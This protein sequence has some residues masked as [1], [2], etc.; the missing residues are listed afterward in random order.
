MR[1]TSR[2]LSVAGAEAFAAGLFVMLV[3]ALPANAAV[4]DVELDGNG[5]D[6]VDPADDWDVITSTGG[7]SVIATPVIPDP[8]GNNIFTTGGSKDIE[9]V[10]SWAW[11]EGSVPD[12]DEIT[13]AMAALYTGNKLYFA[14]DR[15]ANNGD[16]SLGFWL[17]QNPIGLEPDGSFSG[18][19]AVGD[20]L[21]LA[22]FVQGGATTIVPRV[23]R[24]VGDGSGSEGNID[25][26]IVGVE[27]ASA[28][29]NALVECAPWPYEP[30]FPEECPPGCDDPNCHPPSSFFEGGLDLGLLGV[31][32]CFSSFLVETR[33]SQSVSAQLKDFVLGD[34]TTNPTCEITGAPELCEGETAEYCS[35]CDLSIGTYLWEVVSGDATIVG[36]DDGSC[37][38]VQ[39]G[40]TNFTLKLSVVG[41]DGCPGEFFKEVVV[42]PLPVCDIGGPDEV[43]ED[44]EN[45]HCASCGTGDFDYAWSIAGDG[46]ITTPLDGSCVTVLAGADA[47][48]TGVSSYTLTLT[49]T[50]ADGCVDTFEKTVNVN[51]NP[52]VTVADNEACDGD[53]AE[54]CA[55]VALGEYP[56]TFSWTGPGGFVSADSCI[57]V[58]VEGTYSVTVTDANGCEG[59]GSGD[60]TIHDNPVVTVDDNEA[61]DGDTAELCAEVSVGQ[62]PFSFAWTGPGGFVSADSCITVG[63]EGTYSVTVTDANG[64][65]GSGSGDLTIHDNPVVTVDDNEACDGDTA[66]LC[67]GVS[68]GQYPFSFAWTGPGGFVSADSCIT[69]GV[70]GTYSVTVTDANGCEGTGSG[71][72]TIHDNPVVTVDDRDACEGFSAEL[73][74]EVS[75]GQYPFTFAWTGPGGFVSADSCITVGVAGTYEVTVTDDN[76]CVGTGSG[77]LTINPGL[78]IKIDDQEACDGDT[79]ELCAQV[80]GGEYPFSF[81]WTGPGGF[82]S[83]DSCITVGVDGTYSVTVVD[84]NGCEGSGSGDLT[85][86]DNPVVTVDDDEACDGDTAE[87]CAV[88]SGGQYPFTFS[89]TGPGGFVSADSCITVGVEGEYS[90]MVTDDN[91]CEG[92][93]SGDLTIHDNPVVTVD[94][95]EACEGFTAELCAE[96]SVGQYPFTFAW[97][98]PGGFVSADSCIT[99]GD[100]GTYEVTV[101]DDNGCVGTGSGDLTIN[102]G[103]VIK[104]DDQEACDGDT[105]ELCAQ[106]NG[107]EYPFS[108]SWTG[109]GGFVSADSCITVGVDGTYSVT[110]VDVNGCEGSGSGD[111]TV[112]DNPVVTVDD[113][114]ACD[115][116]TAE[117]CA[118]VSGGQYPF[119]FSWTGPGGFVSADSCIAVGV[120]GTYE[121]TVTDDN[122][123]EGSGSG[124][125][126]IHDN[127]TCSLDPPDPLP[128]CGSTGNTLSGPDGMTTYLWELTSA[129]AGWMITGGADQQTVTYTAGDEGDATFQLTITDG[130]GCVGMCDV[131]FSCTP[132]PP[133]DKFCTFTQGFY[134]NPGGRFN[135]IPT[136][137]LIKALIT[138]GNPLVVGVP[139]MAR[140]LEGLLGG[141][142]R[143]VTWEGGAS[144]GYVFED[145]PE[146]PNGDPGVAEHCVIERLPAGGPAEELPLGLGDVTVDPSDCDTDPPLP[147]RNGKYRNVLLGQT[148]TL[149][150]NVRVDENLS[151]LGVCR[152]MKTASVN[153]GPDGCY[154]TEDDLLHHPGGDTT[155]VYIPESVLQKLDDDPGLDTTVGGILELANW[156]LAGLLDPDTDPSPSEISDAAA[157]INEGFD[158]CRFLIYCGEGDAS[159]PML[160]TSPTR[161]DHVPIPFSLGGNYPNPVRSATTIHFTLA[162]RSEIR[163]AVYDVSGRQVALLLE[164]SL[165]AGSHRAVWDMV[166]RGDFSAGIYFYRLDAAGASGSAFT[167]TRRM[168]VLR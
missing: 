93:G 135:G 148:I 138:P 154:G 43:C 124:D 61:C 167:E 83:A 166:D 31:N 107:G 161:E 14:A 4:D 123:C 52:V 94:D 112:H 17:F 72:L 62:Y 22:D 74:A 1:I 8:A 82:V 75:V 16:A 50:S 108:F 27:T 2:T 54:L 109:P 39:A 114:E 157:A 56:F 147:M 40:T 85:V 159:D 41:V 90:V 115:G 60:L 11:T 162:E 131:M 58:G 101:T 12:K 49:V 35:S 98:G 121:V 160:V 44:S 89:W 140:S 126:T 122:G 28:I 32:P 164:G 53:T 158:E 26:I 105:A 128:E 38:D 163:L 46:E 110:V 13:N 15:F 30:K 19:H 33:S 143:S 102:P 125:A 129:P 6:E 87:L 165:R 34:F 7:S 103:L 20:I 36:A 48:L 111:L 92:T 66:E 146:E 142:G 80:N 139:G 81:S 69:V 63:V 120:G 42:N 156:A 24:W 71:D 86:H 59:S 77:D 137:D 67:A 9:D 95:R 25:E 3:A 116:D 76:G 37:V 79:A 155:S 70:E 68:V 106:V 78:V 21:I 96:V 119:T 150:L 113:D 51:P 18:V 64:C 136:L 99:V 149:S 100:A 91:G 141:G 104:I 153:P 151:D 145:C 144:G 55:E 130:N 168:L 45:E 127:P 10:S 118:V 152:V 134:G 133:V 65:E 84:V 57:T 132:P 117:L 88:V 23:F 97:T 5:Y 29:T 47:I 73:C